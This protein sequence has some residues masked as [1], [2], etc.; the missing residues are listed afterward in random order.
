MDSTSERID[1]P[2]A[3]S[4]GIGFCLG[5]A[6]VAWTWSLYP[7]ARDHVWPIASVATGSIAMMLL[8]Y[9]VAARLDVRRAGDWLVIG[10][11]IA[12]VTGAS[13]VVAGQLVEILRSHAPENV[14]VKTASRSCVERSKDSRESLER[15]S[16]VQDAGRGSGSIPPWGLPLRVD[17]SERFVDGRGV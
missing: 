5:A 10:Y 6:S 14:G 7:P 12:L 16:R 11:G 17:S 3:A 13:L 8:L 2:L 15:V 9:L 4:C 1:A